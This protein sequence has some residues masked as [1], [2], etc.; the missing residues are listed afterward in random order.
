MNGDNHIRI[1]VGY[2]YP[3]PFAFDL[4][5]IAPIASCISFFSPG[6]AHHELRIR[7]RQ[8]SL[9]QFVLRVPSEIHSRLRAGH[10]FLSP[11]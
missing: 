1:V 10:S 5:N 8:P 11:F 2:H 3:D 4:A 9:T 7:L 6:A